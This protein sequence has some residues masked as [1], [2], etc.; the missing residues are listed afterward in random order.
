MLTKKM[1]APKAES[2]HKKGRMSVKSAEEPG[3]A[4]EEEAPASA[5]RG[6]ISKILGFLKYRS[7]PF[8]NKG[9]KDILV[10]QQLMEEMFF[11]FKSY[12]SLL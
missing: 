9:Q 4:A 7:D 6:E 11:K 3:N 2:V 5:D 10:A 1:A 8:K 12:S